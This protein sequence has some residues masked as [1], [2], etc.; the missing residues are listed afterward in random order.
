MEVHKAKPIHSWR[1][2]VN[3]IGVIVLGV[4]IALG[5]E[6]AVEALHWRAKVSSAR[7]AMHTE[8]YEDAGYAYERVVLGAC[9]KAQLA[10]LEAKL[11]ANPVA[12]KAFA[13]P[14]AGV[15]YAVPVRTWPSAA[16]EAALASSA[17]AHMPRDEMQKFAGAY[18]TVRILQPQN[19]KEGYEAAELH[20]LSQDQALNDVSRDRLLARVQGASAGNRLFTVASGQFLNAAAALGVRLSANDKTAARAAGKLYYPGCVLP[21]DV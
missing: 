11:A 9:E 18:Q 4:L 3:E 14:A 13:G 6:Q 1:A 8:L 19:L 15:A 10:A 20:M 21:P 2:L 16:W 17:L 7:E 12:W 5:A